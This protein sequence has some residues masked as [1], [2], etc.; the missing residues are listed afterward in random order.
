MFHVLVI[1]DDP[2]YRE[3]VRRILY[4]AGYHVDTASDGMS[5]LK[6]IETKKSPDIVIT[7]MVM[8]PT[9]GFSVIRE[10]NAG[11][12]EI[13]IIVITG[14]GRNFNGNYL[15]KVA[16]FKSVAGTLIKPFR[17]KELL[18]LVQSLSL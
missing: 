4:E 16:G 10:L 1:E 12:P 18:D 7:D 6:Q 15:A 3:L 13:K 2:Q 17:Q 5:G 8:W 11:Y 9:D 14:G